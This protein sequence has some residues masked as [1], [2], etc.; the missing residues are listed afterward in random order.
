[1]SYLRAQHPDQALNLSDLLGRVVC[2]LGAYHVPGKTR[3]S[4]S[5]SKWF[6][7]VK[8]FV[9]SGPLVRGISFYMN[10]GKFCTFSFF[11]KAKFR[12]EMFAHEI[13][14]RMVLC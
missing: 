14:N 13:S 5:K 2:N 7:F 12:H 1:M 9:N 10:P 3:N 6:V 8:H 11:C 4:G